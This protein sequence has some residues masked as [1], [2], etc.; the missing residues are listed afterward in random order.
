VATGAAGAGRVAWAVAVWTEIGDG[1][2]VLAGLPYNW[3]LK[4]TAAKTR[5]ANK[6]GVSIFN[7]MR[8]V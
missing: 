8:L 2:G 5:L 3:Q 4:L 6:M 1:S 7:F